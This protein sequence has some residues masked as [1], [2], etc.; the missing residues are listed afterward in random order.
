MVRIN[1]NKYYSIRETAKH[2]PWINSEP[3]L[4]KLIHHDIDYNNNQL[5]KAIVLKRNKQRRYYIKG[6]YIQNVID[7]SNSGKFVQ[8]GER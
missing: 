4:Q 5:F 7:K 6:E 3:T 1:K 8:N 2:I